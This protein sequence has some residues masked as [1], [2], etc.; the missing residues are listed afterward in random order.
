LITRYWSPGWNSVQSLNRF[1]EEIAGPLRGGDPGVRLIEP[2]SSGGDEYFGEPPESFTPRTGEWLLVPL[3]HLFGSEPLSL[4]TPGIAE[5]APDPYIA[6]GPDDCR[7]LGVGQGDMLEVGSDGQVLHLPLKLMAGLARG[8][9]GVPS[10][11]PG[12]GML[13]HRHWAKLSRRP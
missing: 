11:L 10:G 1:Q 9:A 6:L 8:C 3:Y 5:Q 2:A 4:E 7:E 13:A 12:L